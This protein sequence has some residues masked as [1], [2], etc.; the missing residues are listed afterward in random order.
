MQASC[1]PC[2][3]QEEDSMPETVHLSTEMLRQ[4]L[5]NLLNDAVT[6]VVQMSKGG[7]DWG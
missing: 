3:K 5:N 7:M 1:L 4:I 6:V 2:E